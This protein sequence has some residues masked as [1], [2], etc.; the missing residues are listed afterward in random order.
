LRLELDALKAEVKRMN[1]ERSTKALATGVNDLSTI[2][3][4]FTVV[5]DANEPIFHVGIDS[6]GQTRAIIGKSGG[7]NL[8]LG[9]NQPNV[10][11]IT[12]SDSAGVVRAE[13]NS[14]GQLFIQ[15]KDATVTLG[16]STDESGKPGLF[17]K[18]DRASLIELAI[19]D[20]GGSIK[21]FA[22]DGK[23]VV[24][25]SAS[26]ET[27]LAINDHAGK[28]VISVDLADDGRGQ[29][30]VGNHEADHVQIGQ[31]VGGAGTFVYLASGEG[32]SGRTIITRDDTKPAFSATYNDGREYFAVGPLD[33]NGPALMTVGVKDKAHAVIGAL[34]G[35]AGSFVSLHDDAGIQRANLTT[36][37]TDAPFALFDAEHN[38]VFS[39]GPA[40]G[41]SG[42]MLLTIG[43]EEKAHAALG[44]A[45]S[46]GSYLYLC[47]PDGK[48]RTS[49]RSDPAHGFEMFDADDEPLFAV[50][51][52]TAGGS[53]R[54]V[55]GEAE[56][57]HL[58]LGM[59]NDPIGAAL[60]L[61]D[62]AGKLRASVDATDDAGIALYDREDKPYFT[63]GNP[64]VPT[65]IVG[66]GDKA[67]ARFGVLPSGEGSTLSLFDDGGTSRGHIIATQKST[68]LNLNDGNMRADLGTDLTTEGFAGLTLGRDDKD[69]VI[70]QMN[71]SKGGRLIAF[72]PS[73]IPVARLGPRAGLGGELS[74][75][76]PGGGLPVVAL[77]GGEAGGNIAIYESLGSPRVHMEA[78]EKGTFTVAAASG[79]LF[80]VEASD[81][82][83]MT[84][85]NA[86]GDPVVTAFENTSGLGVVS[87][88]PKSS[89]VAAML[90]SMGIAA[91]ALLGKK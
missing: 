79:A 45:D 39:V 59:A 27:P 43:Q 72:G 55:L 62:P 24:E 32:A 31:T 42:P 14:T 10:P 7:A 53:M 25:L 21:T 48:V 74:V 77:W 12:L 90:G 78:S 13:L 69:L 16:T 73:G 34:A 44:A 5:N 65:V 40:N 8:R 4:P 3:A 20:I 61:Y 26:K 18:N 76:G 1:D 15:G 54:L 91:S 47:D 6:A 87:V 19:E 9:F 50:G 58:F 86:A 41:E 75:A 49:A 81:R 23:S 60:H 51:E 29:I 2:K 84:L 88:G 66:D 37:K 83:S 71:S 63:V 33:A 17:I 52:P 68:T 89:G 11:V 64:Q 30:T 28:P 22:M 80:Q 57:E 38:Q 67:H 85:A 70:L 56:K 46:D 36:D 82:A 35:E